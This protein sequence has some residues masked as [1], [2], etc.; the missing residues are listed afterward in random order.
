[1]ASATPTYT[2]TLHHLAPGA[3]AA[4]AA[5]GWAVDY[6]KERTAF[7]QPIANF[8]NSKFVLAEVDYDINHTLPWTEQIKLLAHRLRNV[9]EDM[10][11]GGGKL[12][13]PPLRQI[14][15]HI[16]MPWRYEERSLFGAGNLRN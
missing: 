2:V 5:L 14:S 11:R 16:C 7:G 8:Q 3:T 10:R 6:V 9:L 15:D 1:M 13:I 4:G 12:A